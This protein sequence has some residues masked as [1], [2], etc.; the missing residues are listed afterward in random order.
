[1]DVTVFRNPDG[2]VRIFPPTEGK[3]R[4][5]VEPQPGRFVPGLTCL[6]AYPLDLIEQ[7]VSAKGIYTCNEILREEDPEGA[8]RSLYHE[9]L[10]YLTPEAFAGKRVLDFGCGSGASTM[11]LHR[12][13]PPCEIVGIELEE[14][15]IRIA[16]L[17]T[18][19][20]G[21]SGVRILRSP[22]PD[23]VPEGI[24]KFH[25]VMFSAVYEHLLPH[26]RR[27]LLPL[28]WSLLE[29]GGVLFLNQT[30]YRYSPIDVHTTRLPLINYLPA[31]MA[32]RYARKFSPCVLPHEDWPTLLRRGI[33]GATVKEI[34]RLLREHGEPELL[35]PMPRVG[36]R[37]DLWF[38]TLSKRKRGVKRT[39]WASL[40][41]I[42]VVTG[43]EVT[44]TLSLAI[45]K[46]A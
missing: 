5:T 21:A 6:T 13:L 8:G 24:G 38:N 4:V 26:E 40:K 39:V 11:A 44:P 35:R 1:M 3:R 19:R 42:K 37:I 43:A 29:P 27:V 25:F 36:D 31:P 10:S 7:I 23:A 14:K 2:L 33:R 28:M 41:A 9:V 12:A 20:L 17:R 32:L 34:L 18:E 45:R 22:S 16:R 30:P 15:L 46:A